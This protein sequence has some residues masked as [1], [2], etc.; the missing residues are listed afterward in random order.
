MA[1]RCSIFGLS[2]VG[3][4]ARVVPWHTFNFFE[5]SPIYFKACHS[6]YQRSR[7]QA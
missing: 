7:R 6:K 2:L 4:A 1:V 5:F 3:L